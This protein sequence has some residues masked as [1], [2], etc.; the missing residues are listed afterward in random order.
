MESKD[1]RRLLAAN[2]DKTND[3]LRAIFTS[4]A[5]ALE[6]AEQ[7]EAKLAGCEDLARVW[8]DVANDAGFGQTAVDKAIEQ[9][10][11]ELLV[12]VQT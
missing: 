5:E 11:A 10:A 3:V 8:Q 4:L 1:I 9:C 7:A 2:E 12:V 6:R